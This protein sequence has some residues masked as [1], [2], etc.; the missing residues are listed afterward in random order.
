VALVRP[1]FTLQANPHEVDDVF[2]VPLSF[3]MDPANHAT[4]LL[5]WQGH[6]REYFS[7]HW[8]GTA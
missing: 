3:V 5:N 1:G 2:D 4:H 7:M 8:Q 6:E